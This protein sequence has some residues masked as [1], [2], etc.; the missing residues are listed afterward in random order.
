MYREMMAPKKRI[1]A[2]MVEKIALNIVSRLDEMYVC[3][4]MGSEVC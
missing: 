1:D 4:S 2:R 3:L